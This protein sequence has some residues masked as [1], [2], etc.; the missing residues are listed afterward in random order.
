MGKPCWKAEG[1]ELSE[2]VADLHGALPE[3]QRGQDRR[4]ARAGEEVEGGVSLQ[5]TE[6]ASVGGRVAYC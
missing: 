5:A 1:R 4:V 3:I 6:K 2:E